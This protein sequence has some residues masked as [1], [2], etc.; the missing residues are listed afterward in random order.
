MIMRDQVMATD[1]LNFEP[2]SIEDFCSEECTG[3]GRSSSQIIKEANCTFE[4][5]EHDS[6]TTNSGLWYC[7]TDC[8]RDSH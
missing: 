5:L 8:F 3:C 2:A 4:E 1:R 6:V 7:H